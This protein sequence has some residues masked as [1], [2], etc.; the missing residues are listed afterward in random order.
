M[1]EQIVLNNFLLF[2]KYQHFDL[3]RINLLTGLNNTGKTDFLKSILLIRQSLPSL[4][5]NNELTLNSKIIKFGTFNEISNNRELFIKIKYDDLIHTF[6]SLSVKNSIEEQEWEKVKIDRLHYY[7]D[8][9]DISDSE[10]VKLVNI[11]RQINFDYNDWNSAM[12]L[13]L[14]SLRAKPNDIIISEHPGEKFH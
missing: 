13:I 5:K 11:L 3:K 4:F 10:L 8:V 2:D 9:P 1:L 12:G 6:Q 14:A 7:Q